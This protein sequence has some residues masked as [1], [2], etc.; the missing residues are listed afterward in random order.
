MNAAIGGNM[1]I[2]LKILLIFVFCYPAFSNNLDKYLTEINKLEESLSKVHLHSVD[3]ENF[4]LD[5][6]QQVKIEGCEVE[7]K[8]Y[9]DRG[10]IQR[11]IYNLSKLRPLRGVIKK[12]N[13]YPIYFGLKSKTFRRGHLYYKDQ[14]DRNQ[15]YKKFKKL[16]KL[17]SKYTVKKYHKANRPIPEEGVPSFI[18]RIPVSDGETS[19]DVYT[20]ENILFGIMEGEASLYQRIKAIKEAKESIYH[21]SL[22]FRA[23][24]VG[25]YLGSLLI[26][27]RQQGLDVKV[28]VDGLANQ[29]KTF[30]KVE[31]ENNFAMYENMMAAGI[32]VFGYSCGGKT[33]RNELR[34]F[35][36]GKLFRRNHEKI[37]L[38]DSAHLG[39][40]ESSKAIVGG[41]NVS[42]NYYRMAGQHPTSWRDF[43]LIVKGEIMKEMEDVFLR[44]YAERGLRYK[45]FK[46]DNK[47]LNPYDPIKEKDK[48]YSF[49]V[50]HTKSYKIDRHAPDVEV[51][52]LLEKNLR[53]L[54]KGQTPNFEVNLN[55]EYLNVEG[56]RFINNRPEESEDYIVE[57]YLD[58]I[59]SA[60]K[61]IFIAN[62][63][64]L[65]DEPVKNALRNAAHRGVKITI[66]TNSEK[67]NEEIELITIVGRYYYIDLAYANHPW[68]ES[69]L[70]W[71]PS[72]VNIYEWYGQKEGEK[73]VM[74]RYHAKVMTV[75]GK[76]SVVGSHNLDNSSKKN[77]ESLV[78]IESEE[79]TSELNGWLNKDLD[80][81]KK[82]TYDEMLYFR[83]PKGGYKIKLGFGKLI[84]EHL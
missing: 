56:A 50:A 83:K 53:E 4:F 82:I 14:N 51:S 54:L 16:H 74:G 44:N 38:L 80:Y 75:D 13:A 67:T 84:E 81:A 17:C 64:V 61:E 29:I 37:L 43:D 9:I 2:S 65:V 18:G 36:L 25:Q 22:D 1:A 63:F 71:D 41:A 35:D 62:Q 66:L 79:L 20:D 30:S 69:D 31:K 52:A 26:E 47:C 32:R 24:T 76:I 10:L 48:Y 73:Q 42:H 46:Y 33:V 23:D 70:F 7:L 78:I 3:T 68:L 60:E 27:K 45:T 28:L 40:I 58:L 49:K 72:Q 39:T 21:Q 6:E 34:G 8:T 57:A 12:K 59:N 19:G 11:D 5:L 77:S 15:D 55:P